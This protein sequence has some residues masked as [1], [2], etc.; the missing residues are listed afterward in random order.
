MLA[1]SLFNSGQG[2]IT[3]RPRRLGHSLNQLKKKT[4]NFYLTPPV[5]IVLNLSCALRP[6][7]YRLFQGIL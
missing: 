6:K 5:R 1:Q 3:D 4:H 7:H 2:F